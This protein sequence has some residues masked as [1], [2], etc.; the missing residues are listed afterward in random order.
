MFIRTGALMSN[1]SRST[2]S[3]HAAS[4]GLVLGDQRQL[5][6]AIRHPAAGK[7]NI[8]AV[9]R[10]NPEEFG[11]FAV[12]CAMID[13][14]LPGVNLPCQGIGDDSARVVSLERRHVT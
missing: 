13:G 1:T 14:Q 6:A 10:I 5:V 4:F 11:D 2:L 9:L 8:P 7:R 3:R 12:I